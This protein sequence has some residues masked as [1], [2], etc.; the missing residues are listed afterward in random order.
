MLFNSLEYLLFFVVVTITYFICPKKIRWMVLLISSY[1]FYMQW[2]EVYAILMLLSTVITYISGKIIGWI[3]NYD[4]PDILKKLTVAVSLILNLSILVIF[5]YGNFIIENINF[6]TESKISALDLLLPVG[7]SFYTFQALSYTIDVY[8]EKIEPC[9]S[10][11]RY[12]L[13]VSFFPQLVAGPIERSVNL[14]PQVCNETRFSWNNFVHGIYLMAIGMFEK[15]VISD[16]LAI[17]IDNVYENINTTSA[18]SVAIAILLFSLQ[19]YCDFGGYSLIAIGS[20][21]ALG[22]N[23]TTN[24]KQ[25]YFAVSITDFW[26]R[27]HISLTTWFKD[28]LYIPLGGNKKGKLRQCINTLI[29]FLVSG[30]WHGASWHFV[31]WGFINGILQIF[32]KL[33]IKVKKSNILFRIINCILVFVLVS[34]IWV[35]FRAQSVN[36]GIAVI[37]KLFLGFDFTT[38]ILSELSLSMMDINIL[39]VG[40]FVLFIFDVINETSVLSYDIMSKSM[41][42]RLFMVVIFA[43]LVLFTIAFGVWGEGFESSAFIYF[44]F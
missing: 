14:L 41:L 9:N 24:F 19:I 27:W 43:F 40:L 8:R 12:A 36:E 30:L 31:F 28:Y 37:Q 11:F 2:N 39:I 32:E 10:F 34:L 22:F 13:F 15:V 33:F 29:V 44:Q 1:Y 26:K 25:P 5:K 35:F 6:Y 42:T 38:D 7:I 23:L 20:A 21:K 4:K 16:R 17:A 3:N 18:L